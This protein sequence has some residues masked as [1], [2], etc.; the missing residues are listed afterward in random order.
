MTMTTAR[1]LER[2]RRYSIS[3]RRLARFLFVVTLLGAVVSLLFIL[4]QPGKWVEP[5]DV[6]GIR[7]TGMGADGT[8]RAFAALT[9]LLSAGVLARFFFHAIKLFGLYSRGAYFTAQSVAHIRQLGI[10]LMLVPGVWLIGL[11]AVL[12]HGSATSPEAG[13]SLVSAPTGQL[14]SGL[15]VIFV[16]WLMDLA[17]EL[18]EEQELVV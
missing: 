1:K 2:I 15:I 9:V 12:T 10:T 18:R 17:R 13:I 16:S 7:F 5:M 11:L 14:V 6:I 4:F 3:L 8:V